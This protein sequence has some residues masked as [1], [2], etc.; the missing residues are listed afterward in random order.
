[1]DAIVPPPPHGIPAGLGWHRTESSPPVARAA[2]AAAV[3]EGARRQRREQE[4]DG[5]SSGLPRA[6]MTETR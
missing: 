2:S 6:G 3:C 1:M 5:G 4:D